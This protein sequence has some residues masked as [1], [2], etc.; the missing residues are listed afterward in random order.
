[1]PA[2][3]CGDN[4]SALLFQSE[5]CQRLR[6]GLRE[7]RLL[8]LL[9][10]AIETVQV[11]GNAACLTRVLLQKEAHAE[12]STANAATGVDTRPEQKSKMPGLW[13]TTQASDVHKRGGADM[14]APPECDEA[15]GDEGTVETV[16][17]HHVRDRAQ[18]DK[19]QKRAQIGLIA[20]F[21]PETAS[22][23]FSA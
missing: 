18:R 3:C 23:Q 4:H 16:Q 12:V 13:R 11:G 6:F 5:R 20:G 10:F 7:R 22:A 1:M 14:F 15:F 2:F 8:D 17:R 19:M 9:T 21:S